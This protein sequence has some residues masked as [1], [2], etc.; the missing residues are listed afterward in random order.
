[1]AVAP[2]EPTADAESV[3]TTSDEGTANAEITA[4]TGYGGRRRS[5]RRVVLSA[6]SLG[7]AVT[8]IALLP[9][10]A[11]IGWEALLHQFATVGPGTTAL[12][13]VLWLAGLWAY[14]YVLSGSLP[15]LS[16]RRALL[17]NAAGSG[18]SNLMPFGGA[19]GVA[20]T[21]AMTAR[22]GFRRP[23]VVVSTLVTGVWNTLSRFLLPAV[24]LGCLLVSGRVPDA[25]LATAA[26]TGGVLLLGIVAAM[27][28]SLYSEAVAD[29]LGRASN[30]LV[31]LLPERSRPAPDAIRLSLLELR[32]S[33][34]AVTRTRWPRLT[35]G[36]I[37]YMALQGVLFIGCLHVAHAAVPVPEAV[38]AFALNRVLTTAV[39]TPGGSG[40][41][42]SATLVTL[43]HFGAAPAPAATAVLLFW[44]FAHVIEIPVGLLAWAGWTL[45]GRSRG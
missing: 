43:L 42:E 9:R 1:M 36:M 27:S 19:V 3:A 26:G 20:M 23:D 4:S 5:V 38:A 21:F 12:L 14:S 25:R 35:L 17:I 34:L 6:I 31:L 41:S 37:A 18:V 13:L 8:L 45:T 11:G 30:R 40:I 7:V 15:G 16:R 10:I 33:T 2:Y 29:R 22:W 44:F 24:G 32:R 39:V 28:A